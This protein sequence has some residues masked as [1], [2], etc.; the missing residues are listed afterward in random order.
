MTLSADVV[1]VHRLLKMILKYGSV[2]STKNHVK[3]LKIVASTIKELSMNNKVKD[4]L[5][6]LYLDWVNNYIETNN[7]VGIPSGWVK[8]GV[9]Q[10]MFYT[11]NYPMNDSAAY[12]YPSSFIKTRT[13][14]S[15]GSSY[16][17]RSWKY[18]ETVKELSI[19]NIDKISGYFNP[20]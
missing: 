19:Y 16:E 5:N 8:V 12:S 9:I 15:Y 6:E 14:Y 17:W 11:Y 10:T 2:M 4:F 1:I 18:I 13:G 7:P 3:M 20:D